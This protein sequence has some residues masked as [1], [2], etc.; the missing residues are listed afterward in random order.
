M[1]IYKVVYDGGTEYEPCRAE[2]ACF[3]T[4]EKAEELL[5]Q[6]KKYDFMDSYGYSIEECEVDVVSDWV[7]EELKNHKEYYEEY[8]E[9]YFK[10]EETL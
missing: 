2:Y 6:F 8:Y 1:T 10:D 7:L 3:S 9:T 5:K 4:R